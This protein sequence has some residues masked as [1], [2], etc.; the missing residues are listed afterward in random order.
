MYRGHGLFFVSVARLFDGCGCR[1]PTAGTRGVV[2]KP[3][4]VQAGVLRC[5]PAANDINE[6]NVD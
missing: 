2:I 1:Q 3:T 6:M 4:E 5:I